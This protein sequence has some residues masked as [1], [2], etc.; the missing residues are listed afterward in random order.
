MKKLF[1][2]FALAF[3]VF[4]AFAQ[5]PANYYNT[6][7][8]LTGTPLRSALHL[9]ID[10]HTVKSY[11]FLYS[12]YTTSDIKPNGKVWDMYS[13]VPGGTPPYTFNFGQTCG[14]Y[15][16]EGDCFNREHSW[17]QS[18]FNSSSPMVSDAFHVYPTDGKVN[19]IRSNYPY[20]EVTT[21]S[22][23][24]LNGSKLGPCS[25][26]GYTGTVFEPIDEYKGDFAR[27]Y[28]YMCTRYYTED[29]GWQTNDMITGAN[30]K[31]WALELMKKWNQQ[32]P[33]S[34]KEISRNN[35]VFA[36]QGNRN[37]FIDHPEYACLIWSGGT[38][39]SIVPTIAN[40]IKNPVSPGI[41]VAVYISATITDDGSISSANLKWGTS[42]TALT[43]TN[44]MG[45]GAGNVY[46]NT[47]AIPGQANG[48][49]VYFQIE[50][51]DNA[52]NV[53][54]S[55][56]QSYTVGTPL[57]P[58]PV[59][60]NIGRTPT[61]PTVNDAVTIRATITDD[62]SVSSA[63]LVWGTD[64]I[65]F[66]NTIVMNVGSNNLYSAISSIP[67]Q[68]LA[69]TVYYKVNASDNISQMSTSAVQQY[70]VTAASS[71]Q[72][73]T[74]LIFS[75]YLEGTSNNKYLEIYNGTGASVN[76]NDYKVNLYSNG[77]TTS[78]QELL[79]S[80]TLNNGDVYII[81]NSAATLYT[82]TATPSNVTFFNGD[83]AVALSKISTSQYID[84]IGRIGEDPG[85]AWTAGN[86]SMLNHTLVRKANVIQG[87][88]T[89]PTSGFPT[90]G[91]EWDVDSVDIATYLGA[92]TMNCP[93]A[94]G[95][96]STTAFS[97]S[98]LCKGSVINVAFQVTGSINS[99]NTYTAELSNSSGSFSNPTTIGTLNSTNLSDV[100]TSMIPMNA[101]AGSGYRVRVIANNPQITGADN[102]S[103]L[104]VNNL[105]TIDAGP[106]VF[107]CKG[108]AAV[109]TAT[110]AQNFYW[111]NGAGDTATVTV[112]PTENT[113][114][115]VTGIDANG[116]S[117][118]DTI[119]VYVGGTDVPVVSQPIPNTLQSSITIGNQWYKNNQM[120]QGENDA[121]LNVSFSGTGTYY[122]IVTD[123]AGCLSDTS[124]KVY[125]LVSGLI[126]NRNNILK[127]FPNPNHGEFT[128]DL[129]AI[130]KGIYKVEITNTIGQIVEQFE[131]DSQ[132][133]NSIKTEL[134]QGLYNVVLKNKKK[135]YSGVIIIN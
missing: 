113:S 34:A 99:N 48:T 117:N 77:S 21:P 26:P 59:I 98:S 30:L 100:I 17:P 13:D 69:T 25:F 88:T 129:N 16:N 57:S 43:N 28:F 84:I 79:L 74:D 122:T 53:S 116:C 54:T 67:S 49:I 3:Q 71:S 41:N 20:G 62:V 52:S 10:N 131:M 58:A 97:T 90:L 85:T 22:I 130:D 23:T 128:F 68:A 114:Y 109:L 60:T 80:G 111:D 36:H 33:V 106:D 37:P 75:E 76:L 101:T 93:T 112:M 8:G 24:T 1:L 126:T 107:I 35:A 89:N 133:M 70:T 42:P 27:T 4:I 134:K 12:I 31:P 92:H 63:N 2:S 40:I 104:T 110:G 102:G 65:N 6:A 73:A 123:V 56:I 94:T 39:C 44:F 46:T 47:V 125:V 115:A 55:S 14:N 64:G 82:G 135:M 91:T 120:L 50:A 105:P 83:D 119:M 72:C 86:I 118:T 95:S 38:F 61:A 51:T 19:G 32:D 121:I 108:F 45:G 11:A 5:I 87:V 81:K 18:W 132:T 78:S 7:T 66:P 9:I 29:S 127:L 96:I 15:S 103:N 124:N